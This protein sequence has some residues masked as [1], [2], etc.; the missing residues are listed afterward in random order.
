[1]TTATTTTLRIL[2]REPDYCGQSDCG[3]PGCTVP[4]HQCR[5]VLLSIAHGDESATGSAMLCLDEINGGWVPM[6]DSIDCWLSQEIVDH[7]NATG[8]LQQIIQESQDWRVHTVRLEA[9]P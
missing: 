5:E 7:G 1:M 3:N 6:G 2:G 8:T 4:A 9:D